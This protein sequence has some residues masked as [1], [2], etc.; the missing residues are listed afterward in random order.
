MLV[1]N[2]CGSGKTPKACVEN[3]QKEIITSTLFLSTLL[4]TLCPLHTLSHGSLAAILGN[5]QIWLFHLDRWRN[6]VSERLRD[7]SKVTLPAWTWAPSY[8][9]FVWLPI[10]LSQVLGALLSVT[11]P[12]GKTDLVG[13]LSTRKIRTNSFIMG[14]LNYFIWTSV[15]FTR[16][17]LP[18]TG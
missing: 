5:G 10:L 9:D 13:S 1:F 12:G 4:G 3:F 16:R 7:L 8:P 14:T 18:I 11:S 2:S 17:R 15:Y 6:W